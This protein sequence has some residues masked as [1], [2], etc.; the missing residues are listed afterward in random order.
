MARRT[1]RSRAA[2]YVS[3]RTDFLEEDLYEDWASSLREEARAAYVSV[4]TVL[5]RRAR[6]DRDSQ[7]AIRLYLR[8]LD[9][10]GYDETA[11]EALIASFTAAGRYGD[12]RHAYGRYLA[13]MREIGVEP[14]PLLAPTTKSLPRRGATGRS[15]TGP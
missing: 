5:A 3:E 9:R 10:D 8:I 1:A 13:R 15:R 14:A 6:R 7:E 11:H 12:A 4:S 2:L